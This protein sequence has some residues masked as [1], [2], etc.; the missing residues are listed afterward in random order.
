MLLLIVLLASIST[1]ILMASQE[2]QIKQHTQ[3]KESLKFY[4]HTYDQNPELPSPY[5]M[6]DGT[7]IV[8]AFTKDNKF[9]LIPVTVE[10]GEPLGYREKEWDKIRIL[11]VDAE[12]FPTLARTGLHSEI[13]LD[14]TRWITDR[15]IAEIT[16]SGRPG[17][18]S[19]EGFI[20]QEEDIISVLKGDNRL[21]KKLGLN[22]PQLAKPLFHVWNIIRWI[23]YKSKRVGRSIDGID[24][25]LYNKKKIRLIRAGGRGWQDS[26]FNDE[27]LGMY[28]IEF[29]IELDE[30]EKTFLQEKYS[31]LS[32]EQMTDF[33]KILS[34]IHTGEMVPFYIM[35]YGFYEGHTGYRADPIAIA[36]IFGLR[37]LEE[38]EKSFEGNLYKTLTEHFTK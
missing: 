31:N 15:S 22:H 23:N 21:A 27:I 34:H 3:T 26:I 19:G 38:I 1:I 16:D 18:S 12:D 25:F 8:V 33:L 36:L 6:E 11:E 37:S 9:T 10:K 24:Y 35:R 2:T 5:T 17:G 30:D 32:N 29:C 7:E 4:P 13:E 28:H 20:S 14:Y